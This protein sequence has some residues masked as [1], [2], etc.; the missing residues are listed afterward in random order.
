MPPNS[1]QDLFDG[2]AQLHR[3]GRLD[4]AIAAYR[5]AADAGF[6]QPIVFYHLWTLL[7]QKGQAQE[8]LEAFQGFVARQAGPADVLGQLGDAMVAK[9]LFEEAVVALRGALDL[10][11]SH[12]AAWNRLGYVLLQSGKCDEAIA[13]CEHAVRLQPDCAAFHSNLGKVLMDVGRCDAGIAATRRAIA[14]DGNDV[15]AHCNLGI[16]LLTRGEFREGWTQYA[17]RWRVKEYDSQPPDIALPRWDGG[18]LSGKRI[19]LRPEQGLGD[20]IQFIRY[21]PMLVQRGARVVVGSQPELYRLLKSMRGIEQLLLPGHPVAAEMHCTFLDL[22]LIFGTVLETIP[23]ETPYLFADEALAQRWKA[24]LSAAGGRLKVGLVWAGRP[25]H[26][27]DRNRSLPLAALAP[28]GRVPGVWL[29]SLQKGDAAKQAQP[30]PSGME[31]ADFTSELQDLADTAALLANLDLVITVDTAV[32]HLAGAMAKPV[33]VLLPLAPDWRWMLDR[34][35]SP[36]YPTMRLYRQ[37]SL[38]DWSTVIQS[39]GQELEQLAARHASAK[40]SNQ[41]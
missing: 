41:F 24:R 7:K 18:D 3:C 33:W 8:S 27:N 15:K 40:S 20:T 23:A 13:A 36:W 39:V 16:M 26:A 9:G 22:P 12:L 30:P 35:D 1:A 32:A 21:I 11:P 10:E 28:L 17:Y 25:S 34:P 31:L 2:A 6:N 14:L 19:F 29:C 5:Q 38:G 37:T 4:E